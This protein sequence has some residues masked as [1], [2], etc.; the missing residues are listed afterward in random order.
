M[1]RTRLEA[2]ERIKQ[3]RLID[4]ELAR[5]SVLLSVQE[6]HEIEQVGLENAIERAKLKANPIIAKVL[7]D[8]GLL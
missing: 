3:S 7:S 1:S 5:N 2:L 4:A 6:K 8:K